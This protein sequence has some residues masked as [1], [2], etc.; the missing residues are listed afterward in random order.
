MPDHLRVCS[1]VRSVSGQS[2][3]SGSFRD[4]NAT[5]GAIWKRRSS[6][7]C[8]C[9]DERSGFTG[10]R[11]C[12]CRVPPAMGTRPE[13]PSRAMVSVSARRLCSHSRPVKNVSRGR[14]LSTRWSP[15]VPRCTAKRRRMLKANLLPSVFFQHTT[16]F[17]AASLSGQPLSRSSPRKPMI[18]WLSGRIAA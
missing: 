13:S 12:V 17:R 15:D 1:K 4:M 9:S 16:P 11:R 18:Q 2:S 10:R 8:G 14:A 7:R 3:I 5:K 6:K